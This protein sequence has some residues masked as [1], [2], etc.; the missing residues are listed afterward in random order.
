M[1][2]WIIVLKKGDC[3]NVKSPYQIAKEIGVTPPAVYKRLKQL[4]NQLENHMTKTEKGKILI[5]DVGEEIIKNSFSASQ[6]P[7][8]DRIDEQVD[9]QINALVNEQVNQQKL[10]EKLEIENTYLKEELSKQNEQVRKQSDQIHILAERLAEITR[11]NQVLLKIEQEHSEQ[12]ADAEAPKE[13]KNFFQRLFNK[14]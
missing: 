13:N 11:N 8:N 14:S 4:N 2:V 3:I 10:I 1:S 6:K 9:E 5:D 7:I 12:E